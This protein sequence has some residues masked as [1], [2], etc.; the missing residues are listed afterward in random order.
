MEKSRFRY[1]AFKAAFTF[2]VF[3]QCQRLATQQTSITN[4]PTDPFLQVITTDSIIVRWD[5]P[6]DATQTVNGYEL[7]YRVHGNGAWTTLKNQVAAKDSPWVVVY[8][9]DIISSDS[10]FDFAVRALFQS[11]DQ[12]QMNSSI[13]SLSSPSGGWFVKW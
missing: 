7:L 12:S 13:D 5:K 2:F 3:F 8:R 11:G 6:R 9:S 10:L 4:F 1:Q